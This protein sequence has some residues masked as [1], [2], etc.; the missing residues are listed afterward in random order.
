[1]NHR[2][3]PALVI[4]GATCLASLAG[5]AAMMYRLECL[6]RTL[7]EMHNHHVDERL[8]RLEMQHAPNAAAPPKLEARAV[9]E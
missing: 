7:L 6:E 1:M 4:L 3:I 9:A 2:T 5:N 8:Q